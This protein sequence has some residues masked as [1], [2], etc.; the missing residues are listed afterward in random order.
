MRQPVEWTGLYFGANAGYGS[1]RYS[2][3]MTFTGLQPNFPAARPRRSALASTELSGTEVIGSGRPSG[4]I[5]GGQIGFNWQAGM[6]VFGGEIDG[7][8]SGQENTFTTSCGA[9]C[10]ATQSIKIRSLSTG[11][12]R[13][14]LALIGSC[15]T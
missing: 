4:A 5:A 9:G 1:G 3:N 13:F 10:T 2:S 7:Q 11:R 12:G 6:F 14:G 8:W 15:L